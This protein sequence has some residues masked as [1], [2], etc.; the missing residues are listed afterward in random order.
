M[1]IQIG[2]KA[3][4]LRV[5]ADLLSER[6]PFEIQPEPQLSRRLLLST[7]FQTESLSKYVL[8]YEANGMTLDQISV[9]EFCLN[10]S[11]DKQIFKISSVEIQAELLRLKTLFDL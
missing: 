4:S 6:V 3:F 8:L 9:E 10:F 1:W 5:K 2:L 11:W 7:E